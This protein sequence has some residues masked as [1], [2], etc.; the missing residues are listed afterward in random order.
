MIQ[1]TAL[2]AA[3]AGVL[4]VL[5]ACAIF[6][7]LRSRRIPN[8]LVGTGILL[9]LASHAFGW[10]SGVQSLAGASPWSPLVGMIYGLVLMLPLYLL[11]AMG[12]GDVKLMAMVG[13]LVGS[14]AVLS[15]VPFTL[16]CGGLV[17][18]VYMFSCG[19]A[20][21]TLNNVR[22]ILTDWMIRA[23]TG[24]AGRLA[25]LQTTAARLPYGVAIAMGTACAVAWPLWGR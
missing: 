11:R 4:V 15:A 18:V 14:D 23:S 17:S 21:Q 10:L 5:L 19:V 8:V 13:A 2:V 6:T 1:P 9:A 22:F 25:P 3:Q 20:V 7:D 16:I 12:A 24:Q